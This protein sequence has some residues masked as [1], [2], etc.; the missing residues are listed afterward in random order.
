MSKSKNDFEICGGTGRLITH[1]H[2]GQQDAIYMLIDPATGKPY[3]YRAMVDALMQRKVH[4][5]VL[6]DL[7]A[8]ELAQLD[9]KACAT[10]NAVFNM[11]I[12]G[13]TKEDAIQRARDTL[14]PR[15]EALAKLLYAPQWQINVRAG[16][17]TVEQLVHY[18]KDSI[19]IDT[20]DSLRP[21]LLRLLRDVILPVMGQLRL[22]ELSPEAIK[23]SMNAIKRAL[24]KQKA[25]PQ[26][27]NDTTRACKGLLR[28]ISSAGYA[29]ADDTALLADVIGSAKKRNQALVDI[30]RPDHLDDAQR[31]ALFDLLADASRLRQLFLISLIYC[32]MDAAEISAIQMGDIQ[33]LTLKSGDRCYYIQVDKMVRKINKRYATI[34][35]SH[36]DFPIHRLR[37]VV[38]APWAAEIAVRYRN[39]LLQSYL[40]EQVG[41][42]RLAEPAPDGH[43]ANPSDITNEVRLLLA[44]AGISYAPLPRTDPDGQV[45]MHTYTPDLAL[46]R[47]DAA[48][49]ARTRCGANLAMLHAMF[50]QPITEMDEKSYIDLLGDKYVVA[51]YLRLRRY[52]PYPQPVIAASSA[53]T[54]CGGGQYELIVT[55]PTD[56]PQTLTLTSD[57]AILTC[58]EDIHEN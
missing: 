46:L 23:K 31:Q 27:H 21:K 44:Q 36:S 2:R 50:G 10:P 39:Q 26:R 24:K 55:N 35:A 29:L 4:A 33:R 8:A 6:A 48:Y 7:I 17:V 14:L 34:P 45:H 30:G 58:W 25:S 15:L 51:R 41:N 47:R 11:S 9:K 12:R 57:Y 3:T 1:P 53:D 42:M 54:L 32:G 38:L 40:P 43:I 49:L 18:I 37:R 22:A 52:T 5:P 16:T 20:P 56:Q 28:A 13:K 19:Y